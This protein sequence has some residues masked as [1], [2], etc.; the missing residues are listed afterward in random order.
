MRASSSSSKLCTP[1]DSRFTP[2]SREGAKALGFEGAGVRLHR[3]LGVGQHA[4]PRAH[5][6][7]QQVDRPGREQARRA[8]ADEDALNR[9]APDQRERGLEVRDQRVDVAALE[10]GRDPTLRR[11]ARGTRIDTGAQFVRI[12]VAVRAL[13]NAPRKVQVERERRKL[14]QPAPDAR[15]FERGV[16]HAR[17]LATSARIAIARWLTL[18][19]CSGSSSAAVQPFGQ[20]KVRVV[21]ETVAAARRRDHFAVPDALGDQRPGILGVAREHEHAAVVG[22]VVGMPAKLG[23]QQRVVGRVLRGTRVVRRTRRARDRATS[24]GN[25]GIPDA[26]RKSRVARRANSRRAAERVGADAGIVGQRRQSGEPSKRGAPSPARSRRS[27]DAARPPRPRPSSDCA[28]SAIPSGASSA[29]SSRSLPALLDASTTRSGAIARLIRD[30]RDSRDARRSPRAAP[31][32]GDRFPSARARAVRRPARARTARLRRCPASRR[33]RRRRSSRRSCRCRTTSPRRSPDRGP[34]RRARSR[35]RPPRPD[36]RSATRTARQR[37]AAW[38]PRRCAATHAPVIAAVRVPPSAC[39]TSQSICIERSPSA[40]RSNTARRLRPISRWISWVRPD[41]LPRAASRSIRVWVERGSIPYSAVTQP[42]PLPRRKGGTFS[43]DARGAKHA[44]ATELD[45]HR[46]LGVAGESARDPHDA[47]FVG[48]AAARSRVGIR[49]AAPC[50]RLIHAVSG[51]A[52]RWF[53]HRAHSTRRAFAR[54]RLSA[55]RCARSRRESRRS[56]ARSPRP[57]S[58]GST[59]G[60]SA[61]I[62]SSW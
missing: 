42:R 51:G 3:D 19:L 46:P 18:F 31:P 48:T 33:T 16:H 49:A 14:A 55:S 38:R 62:R 50:C 58:R 11:L 17:R 13:A 4:Q 57:R 9:S 29:E 35:P 22:A 28:T 44:G 7:E 54:R 56:C 25:R 41:C 27:S 39:S 52:V 59:R 24:R 60:R 34:A 15:R 40:A 53:A 6:A 43:S 26:R 23:D 21:A 45:Q 12:E 5:R 37:R 20:Q 8:A 30:S 61:R 1:I 36:R 47:Q 32:A 10:I 2:A